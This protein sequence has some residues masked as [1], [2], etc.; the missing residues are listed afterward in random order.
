MVEKH[1]KNG[2]SLKL[3]HKRI[4]CISSKQHH[5]FGLNHRKIEAN[6]TIIV[7]CWRGKYIIVVVL[8]RVVVVVEWYGSA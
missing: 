8:S 1:L 6:S 2:K 3:K 4:K 7:L 5:F